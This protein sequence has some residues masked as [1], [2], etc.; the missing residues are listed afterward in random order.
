MNLLYIQCHKIRLAQ[1]KV[2]PSIQHS[3]P[4]KWWATAGGCLVTSQVLFYNS[5]T[6]S[7]T[8]E[9]QQHRTLVNEKVGHKSSDNNRFNNAVKYLM[10]VCCSIDLVLDI[11]WIASRILVSVKSHHLCTNEGS[12]FIALNILYVILIHYA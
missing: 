5:A 10:L 3:S 12:L 6:N 1:A 2:L 4:R 11:I 9:Q 7:Q 8:V